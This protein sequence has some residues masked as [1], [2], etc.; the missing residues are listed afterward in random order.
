MAQYSAGEKVGPFAANTILADTGAQAVE[1]SGDVCIIIS[2][3]VAAAFIV[4]HVDA[5]GAVVVVNGNAH[6]QAIVLG[7]NDTKEVDIKINVQP[8]ESIRVRSRGAVAAGICQASMYS[9]II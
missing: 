3:T 7:V 1:T 4:E 6:A 2:S 9:N 8:T 5:N